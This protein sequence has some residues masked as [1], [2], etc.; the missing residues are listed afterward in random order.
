MDQCT[1]DGKVSYEEFTT[2]VENTRFNGY[3]PEENL[4]IFQMM[5]LNNDY[6]ISED[7]LLRYD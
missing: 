5:D 1:T 4:R 3:T 7:E 2:F 6:K